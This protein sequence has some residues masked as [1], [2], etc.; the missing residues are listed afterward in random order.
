MH[1]TECALFTASTDYGRTSANVV[2][3]CKCCAGGAWT[4]GY[5]AWGSLLGRRLSKHGCLVCCLDYRNFPQ[6]ASPHVDVSFFTLS[7]QSFLLV[8][9]AAWSQNTQQ[10]VAAQMFLLGALVPVHHSVEL[11]LIICVTSH[12][13]HVDQIACPQ[14][15]TPKPVLSLSL[16]LA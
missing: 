9:P 3:G 12:P 15:T 11:F 10:K 16:R 14:E 6:V 7:E 13:V 4:I 5:K 2:I 1:V 8:G